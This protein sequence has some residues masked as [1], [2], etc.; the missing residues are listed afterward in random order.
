MFRTCVKK[1]VET[2][3]CRTMNIAFLKFKPKSIVAVL[4]VAICISCSNL[5]I[6]QHVY[7][8]SS[9]NVIAQPPFVGSN[10]R[11]DV[12]GVVKNSGSTPFEVLLGLKVVSKG[13]GSNLSATIKEPT[14]GRIIYPS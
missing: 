12:V 2:N 5:I 10:G 11:V 6:I 4:V 1:E 8:G 3:A 7:A 14:Y 13:I 9:S